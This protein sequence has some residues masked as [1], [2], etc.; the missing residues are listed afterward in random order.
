M[1]CFGAPSVMAW[2]S[3]LGEKTSFLGCTAFRVVTQK[4]AADDA[5]ASKGG[6]HVGVE[7]L[8]ELCCDDSHA[9]LEIISNDFGRVWTELADSNSI[10]VVADF[11]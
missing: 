11:F 4:V 8:R 9:T 5:R 2:I 6:E 7:H 3:T 10:F 1:D